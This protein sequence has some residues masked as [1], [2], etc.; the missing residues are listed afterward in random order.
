MARG[1]GEIKK[2]APFSGLGGQ[3]VDDVSE[4]SE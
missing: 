1:G 3:S 4:Y 2:S